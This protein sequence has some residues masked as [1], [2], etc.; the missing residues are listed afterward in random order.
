[1]Q[2]GDVFYSISYFN[3]TTFELETSNV[4]YICYIYLQDYDKLRV[5]SVKKV[6]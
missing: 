1:M 4:C 5:D 6:Y 2:K 3:Y